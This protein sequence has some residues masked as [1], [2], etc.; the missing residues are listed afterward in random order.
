MMFTKKCNRRH[1]RRGAAVVEAA[2]T[3]PILF[4]VMFAGWEFARMNVIRNSM[5]N[6]A[7]EAARE[8]MLPGTSVA[9]I[10]ARGQAVLDAVGVNGAVIDVTPGVIDINTPEVTVDVTVPVSGN[11]LGVAKF[12]TSGNLEVSCTLSRELQPGNF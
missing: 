2:L 9:A 10:K 3:L 5:D 7:Y 8:S 1:A 12:M 11:S 4:L 6:A